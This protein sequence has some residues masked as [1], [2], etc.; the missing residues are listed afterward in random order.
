M[1]LLEH[2]AK[3]LAQTRGLPVPKGVLFDRDGNTD[4]DQMPTAPW[5]VKAQVPVGGRGKAGAIVAAENLEDVQRII[6]DLKNKS[7]HGHQIN[8]FR[9]ETCVDAEYEVFISLSIDAAERGIRVLV[10]EQGG[11]DVEA[12]ADQDDGLNSVVVD[13]SLDALEKAIVQTTQKLPA[14]LRDAVRSAAK[15]LA[16]FFLDTEA[17]LLEV[18][19]LFVSKDGSWLLGDLKLAIDPS[20]LTRQ[21]ELLKIIE[22]RPSAYHE[23]IFKLEE[24]FDFIELDH[25]GK[26]GLLTTGAGL[27]MMLIDELLRAGRHP[28]NFCDIRSGQFKGSPER[29][30]TALHRFTKAPDITAVLVNIF[31]GITDLADFARLLIE[32]LEQVPE[33]KTPMVAR[34]VGNNFAE[35]KKLIA[36]SGFDIKVEED[37]DN[38]LAIVGAAG[39]VRNVT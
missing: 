28:F 11:V 4:S 27:S 32:A 14:H 15:R 21:P 24:G 30:V 17:M 31:A 13:L 7:I 5:M 38:A 1:M 34:L 9:V 35:A 33:F 26:I 3:Q 37:L 39:E 18:N 22:G 2:D 6:S 16:A 19:P 29:L 36:Q 10:V 23:Q 20:A 25:H 8:S 12:A